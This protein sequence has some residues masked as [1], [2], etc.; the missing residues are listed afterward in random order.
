MK[1]RRFPPPRP[2]ATLPAALVCVLCLAAGCSFLRPGKGGPAHP[3]QGPGAEV[4][5]WP[6]PEEAGRTRPGC[7]PFTAETVPGGSFVVAVTDSVLPR[8]APVP[9]NRS[10]RLVFAQLYETLVR[11]D[12]R[13]DLLPG[14]ADHWSCTP[15]SSTWVFFL[16]PDAVFWDGTRVDAP[17]VKAAWQRAQQGCPGSG[18]RDPWSWLDPGE[19]TVRVVDALRL[20]IAL[21]EPQ[22]D[23]PLLLAHPAFAVAARRPGW[24]WPVGSGPAR[25]GPEAALPL[26]DLRYRPNSHHPRPARWRE[27]TLRV[28]PTAD[29]RDLADAHWDLLP[30]QTLQDSLFYAAVPGLEVHAL[31]DTRTYVLVRPPAWRSPG[32]G[33][34]LGAIDVPA[35]GRAVAATNLKPWPSLVIPGGISGRC[36]QLHGPAYA[37]TAAPLAWGLDELQL[38]EDALVYR[39]GDPAARQLAEFTAARG[40]KALRLVPL[41]PAPLRFVLQWQMAA[42]GILTV[43]QAYPSGCLQMASLLS[44]FSWLRADDTAPPETLAAASGP[45]G[46]S[47]PVL[48]ADTARCLGAA[49]TWLAARAHLGGVT[50][51]FDGTPL[52]GGLGVVPADLSGAHR[53]R[54]P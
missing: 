15:D 30:V 8:H 6:G 9:H 27:L 20:S 19:A 45:H 51:A 23:F 11:V 28:L 46:A 44:S 13:G 16:R 26:P 48:A 32:P 22:E 7:S 38:G 31:P 36:P 53:D 42:A 34:P 5:G 17:A 18:P 10:E 50:L 49:H 12:C 29:A 47:G 14:L 52:L 1:I 41:D 4:P 24:T 40:S 39:A 2:G 25:L 54:I 33:D 35:A 21:P 3:V 37:A 43:D